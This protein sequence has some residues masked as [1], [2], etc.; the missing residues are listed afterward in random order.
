MKKSI[1]FYSNRHPLQETLLRNPP[2]N[3][4]INSNISLSDL[5]VNNEYK[6]LYSKIKY[7]YSIFLNTIEFPRVLPIS[8]KEDLLLTHPGI[9]PL[10]TKP[11]MV[12]VEYVTS[13]T[14]LDYESTT[15]KRL[16]KRVV[17]HLESDKCKFILPYSDACLK[18]IK[19][20][21]KD[22][23]DSFEDKLRVFPPAI[24]PKVTHLS[25]ENK[26][27]IKFL[28]IESHFFDSGGREIIDV[29]E[30]I[31]DDNPDIKLKLSII[32]GIPPH[33]KELFEKTMKKIKTIPNINY[34]GQNLKRS[35]LFSDF[36]QTHDILLIPS[37]RHTFGYTILEAMSC[38]MP[39]IGSDVSAI[40]EMVR[41]GYNG[42]IIKAPIKF[43]NKYY[44]TSNE[45]IDNYRKELLREE[46]FDKF[47][48]DLYKAMSKYIDNQQLIQSH[49]ENSLKMVTTGRYSVKTQQNSL[50]ELYEKAV[51]YK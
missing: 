26:N 18:S 8:I 7:L 4:T 43:H 9:L 14:N 5:E 42:F 21:Y 35:I 44:L 19:N 29:F 47:K 41:D 39:I 3:I 25:K 40:P 17:K 46:N 50:K 12:W 38:G 51:Q 33:H 32:T 27:E 13:L 11:W 45:F 23:V 34:I 24:E 20:S 10:T 2:E 30:K 36:Y 6:F 31:Q 28:Y 48:D 15:K 22:Y 37:F 16:K 1:F 49:G